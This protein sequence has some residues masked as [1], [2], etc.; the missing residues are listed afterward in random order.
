MRNVLIVIGILFIGNTSAQPVFKVWEAFGKKEIISPEAIIQDKEGYL[1]IGTSTRGLLR[2]DGTAL[3]TFGYD[4]EDPQSVNSNYLTTLVEWQNYIIGGTKSEGWFLLDK[5][6]FRIKRFTISNV[7]KLKDQRI[8]DILVR[9]DSLY[10]ATYNGLCIQNLLTQEIE[11]MPVH[12]FSGGRNDLLNIIMCLEPHPSD[13]NQLYLGSTGGLLSYDISQATYK[14]FPMPISVLNT[15]ITDESGPLPLQV[16]DI[17]IDQDHTLYMSTWGGGLLQYHPDDNTWNRTDFVPGKRESSKALSFNTSQNVMKYN[18]DTLLITGNKF[19]YVY[20]IPKQTISALTDSDA[21]RQDGAGFYNYEFL[22]MRDGSIVVTNDKTLVRS[23][24][25]KTNYYEHISIDY[26]QI[27]ESDIL[28]KSELQ[29]EVHI[30][31]GPNN[32]QIFLSSPNFNQNDALFFKLDKGMSN[33]QKVSDNTIFLTELNRSD[34]LLTKTSKGQTYTLPITITHPIY[35]KWWFYPLIAILICGI[36]GVF[37]WTLHQA[38]LRA[39]SIAQNYE[40]KLSEMEMQTLRAQMN[41]HFLFNS[42]NAIKHYSLTRTP[43]ETADYISKFSLLIRK[44]LQNSTQ[45]I[46]P[47]EQELETLKLY[48]E[49]EAL[50]FQNKFDFRVTVDPAL[51]LSEILTPPLILQP[52]IE[53][54]IWHGL[55]HLDRRGL[56]SIDIA[57]REKNITITIEDNGIGRKKSLELKKTQSRKRK[58]YGIDITKSR[59]QLIEKTHNV[60]TQFWIEDL[61]ATNGDAI[62]TRVTLVIPKITE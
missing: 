10:I 16:R 33:W 15:K 38:R 56:L 43:Y 5:D 7:P 1:W 37:L 40:I 61:Y 23:E 26:I 6:N 47:L 13:D 50:R 49:V 27:N 22:R 14:Y 11:C 12:E 20:D 59:I 57:G 25:T 35:E 2:F 54:A 41:P 36:I 17:V 28:S 30:Q 52:F 19:I 44:I 45:K 31:G 60:K 42:L 8:E 55:M 48:V 4:Q 53:N 3:Y 24:P 29:N 58:S 62:G 46:L 18:S 51:N 39:L 21:W 32:L 34:R 9:G